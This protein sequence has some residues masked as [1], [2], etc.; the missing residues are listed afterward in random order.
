M[1]QCKYCGAEYSDEATE[2]LIDKTPLIEDPVARSQVQL[3][4]YFTYSEYPIPVSLVILSYIFFL[5]AG[6]LF[7]AVFFLFVLAVFAGMPDLV[8]IMP[9]IV[10]GFG[11]G[12]FWL[13]LS[14]GL[15]RGSRGWRICALIVIWLGM[16]TN[17]YDMGRFFL[18]FGTPPGESAQFFLIGSVL[19]LALGIWLLRVLTRP[20]IREW[21]GI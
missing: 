13:L 3:P 8:S 7:G 1:R 2:C 21:F 6:I 4:R 12:M 17:A 19:S 5:P 9:L 20:D 10:I 15:R 11:F 16:L 14:R 18:G